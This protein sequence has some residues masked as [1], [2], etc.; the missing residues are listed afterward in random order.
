MA[1]KND[2]WVIVLLLFVLAI[3][4]FVC[5]SQRD[6]AAGPSQDQFAGPSS[7]PHHDLADNI[8]ILDAGPEHE[9]AVDLPPQVDPQF[10]TGP[11]GWGR[12]RHTSEV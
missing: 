1:R 4:G 5:I 11:T 2:G 12:Q 9:A 3:F 8:E 7:P 6:P 10:G